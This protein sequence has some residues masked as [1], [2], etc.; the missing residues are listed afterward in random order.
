M[1]ARLKT[2]S[3]SRA[4]LTG[5]SL[6]ERDGRAEIA[7]VVVNMGLGEPPLARSSTPAPTNWRASPAR[8]R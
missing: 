4:G 5:S 6:Q 2:A 7:K 3:G 1:N 8:N